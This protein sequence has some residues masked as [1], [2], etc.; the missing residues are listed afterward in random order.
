MRAIIVLC[1]IGLFSNCNSQSPFDWLEGKWQNQKN[2]AIEEWHL[3]GDGLNGRVYKLVNSDTVVQE[4]LDLLKIERDWF[5]KADV[6]H[7]PEPT[8]FKISTSE[9]NHFICEN[10]EHDFPKQIEYFYDGELLT[11]I[12]SDGGEKKMGFQFKKIE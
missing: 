12:I 1:L 2:G 10:P 4:K 5:Y 3:T 7:N 6:D 11:V 8:L 9:N